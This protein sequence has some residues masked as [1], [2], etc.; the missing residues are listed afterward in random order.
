M[1]LLFPTAPHIMTNIH[2]L[3]QNVLLN[4]FRACNQGKLAD[5]EIELSNIN[6]SSDT[7]MRSY[8]ELLEFQLVLQ[9]VCVRKIFLHIHIKL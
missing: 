7:L 1:L 3:F 2:G 4:F 8:S 9:K 6:A 5:L